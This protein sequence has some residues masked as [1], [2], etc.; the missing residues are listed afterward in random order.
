MISRKNIILVFACTAV[1]FEALDIAIINLAMPLIQNHYAISSSSVHWAQTLYILLYGGFLIAGGKLSDLF[2][3]KRMF[4]TGSALFLMTSLGAGLSPE[5][6]MLVSFRALQGLAAALL[7]PAAFSIIT[8]TFTESSERSKAI[9]IFSSFAAIGSGCGLSLGGIIASAVGW[10]W[11]FFINVPVIIVTLWLGSVFIEKDDKNEKRKIPDIL[12]GIVLTSIIV[13][14]SYLV[15]ILND[16][17]SHQFLFMSLLAAIVLGMGVFVQRSKNQKNPLIDESIFRNKS[18]RKGIVV[19]MLMGAFFTGYLFVISLVFQS[20][21]NYSSAVTGFLLFPFS[22]LSAL[23][24]KYIMPLLLKKWKLTQ[25]AVIGMLLMTLGG[26]LL[27]AGMEINYSLIVILM[28]VAC[29]TG[30]GIAISFTSLMIMSIQSIPVEHHGV[31]TGLISTAYFLGG[32]LGLSLLSV[33]MQSE[34]T[35]HVSLLTVFVLT[36]YALMGVLI[37]MRVI[38]TYAKAESSLNIVRN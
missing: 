16:V 26:F 23:T 27:A 4:M 20:N 18:T 17:Q 34:N 33:F 31:A 28:S 37:L 19:T 14:A 6:Y 8:N 3:R 1:F 24:G 25:I 22:V 11:I 30:F 9:G 29:V 10:Q 5:F 12:S 15:H 7:M 13:I 2:G 38:A 32:G 21:M 35:S 36:T